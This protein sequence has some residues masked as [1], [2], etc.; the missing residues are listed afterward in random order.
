V[1][2]LDLIVLPDLES[3]F[4]KSSLDDWGDGGAYDVRMIFWD[5]DGNLRLGKSLRR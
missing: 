1:E 2:C 5:L 3:P 4:A